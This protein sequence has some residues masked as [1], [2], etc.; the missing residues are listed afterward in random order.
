MNCIPD[1]SSKIALFYHIKRQ[2]KTA[3]FHSMKK[4]IQILFINVLTGLSLTYSVNAQQKVKPENGDLFSAGYAAGFVGG[5]YDA[6][7]PY[8]KLK[9]HGDFGLGA[10]AKLD[11]ELILLNGKFYQTRSTGKTTL[12]S[13][14]GKTPYAVVCFFRANKIF[15]PGKQLTKATLFRYLDSVLTNQNGIYAIHISGKFTYVKTRA[16]PPVTQKPYLPLAAMLGR[17]RFFESDNIKGDLVG[18][19]LPAFLEGPHISGYHFHFLSADK[20]HGGHMIDVTARDITI[21]VDT[22]NSYTIDLPQ[23][24]DFKNFDFK[25]DRKEEIKSVENGKKQ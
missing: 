15:K 9:L 16:F 14:T 21:E 2:L 20:A 6:Y 4:I 13:D 3:G 11:G 1:N 17:Q 25:K 10:P 12:M 5:L 7:Y 23:T 19:K 22:L 18:Y 8:K 24:T